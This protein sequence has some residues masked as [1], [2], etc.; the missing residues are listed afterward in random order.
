MLNKKGFVNFWMIF[1]ILSGALTILNFSSHKKV[2]NNLKDKTFIN[3]ASAYMHAA[4]IWYTT[5]SV[6]GDISS[7]TCVTFETLYNTKYVENNDYN[8]YVEFRM[9]NDPK[10]YITDGYKMIY[11][12]I[13]GELR[14]SV[15][16]ANG[17]KLTIPSYCK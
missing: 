6:I 14:D 4:E 17:V 2:S 15:E 5:E 1:I 3:I 7:D 12:A 10:I 13:S 8:G 11:G 9:N 16:D